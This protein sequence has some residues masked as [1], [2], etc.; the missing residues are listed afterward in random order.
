MAVKDFGF[1]RVRVMAIDGMRVFRQTR[2]VLFFCFVTVVALILPTLPVAP[3]LVV[4]SFGVWD[5]G[6]KRDYNHFGR[7]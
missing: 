6:I 7:L 4:V 3:D 2:G 1:V 5:V